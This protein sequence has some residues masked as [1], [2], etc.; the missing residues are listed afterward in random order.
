MDSMFLLMT[1]EPLVTASPASWP[2]WEVASVLRA[3]SSA[4]LCSSLIAVA[5]RS[6]SSRWRE[7]ASRAS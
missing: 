5:T 6:V 4:L 1:S 7:T 3:I 2:A